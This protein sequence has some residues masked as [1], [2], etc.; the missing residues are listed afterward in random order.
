MRLKLKKDKNNEALLS[1]NVDAERIDAM[2]RKKMRVIG[3]AG[4]LKQKEA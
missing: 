4:I 1:K 3:R 2:H